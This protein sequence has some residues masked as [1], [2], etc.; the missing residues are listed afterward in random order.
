[1]STTRWLDRARGHEPDVSE[2]AALLAAARAGDAEAMARC[3]SLYENTRQ[4]GGYNERRQA[5][6][7]A[8]KARETAASAASR[9]EWLARAL[10]WLGR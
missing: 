7:A 6:R 10:P 9:T 1:M 3:A 2:G 4:R 5:A 8:A